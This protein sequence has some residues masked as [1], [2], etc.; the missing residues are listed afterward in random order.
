MPPGRRR[1]RHGVHAASCPG[2]L[3]PGKTKGKALTREEEKQPKNASCLLELAFAK[4]QRAFLPQVTALVGSVFV[5]I[6]VKI[7]GYKE[8]DK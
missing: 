3:A 5:L 6:L 7:F 4:G 2:G 1:R 8:S